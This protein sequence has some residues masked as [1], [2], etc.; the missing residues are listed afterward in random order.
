MYIGRC[1]LGGGT[2][3]AIYNDETTCGGLGG[4]W[5]RESNPDDLAGLC[6]D[7]SSGI[8]PADDEVALV[9][10]VIPSARTC[11]VGGNRCEGDGSADCPDRCTMGGKDPCNTDTDCEDINQGECVNDPCTLNAA[12][13]RCTE[14]YLKIGD[15][16]S[17]ASGNYMRL[18][19]FRFRGGAGRTIRIC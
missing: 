6:P 3:T 1:C 4:D 18:S 17:L 2:T 14:D 10:R 7:Y 5:R 9:G 11:Q 16:Y 12:L 8:A 13:N 15:D 19:Q